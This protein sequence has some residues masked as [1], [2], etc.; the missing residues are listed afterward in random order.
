MLSYKGS[1]HATAGRCRCDPLFTSLANIDST[2]CQIWFPAP[3]A[4]SN[5]SDTSSLTKCGRLA[6]GIACKVKSRSGSSDHTCFRTDCGRTKQI[7]AKVIM[8]QFFFTSCVRSCNSWL[9]RALIQLNIISISDLLCCLIQEMRERKWPN[10]AGIVLVCI[11][12]WACTYVRPQP[13]IH[14]H[15]GPLARR[16]PKLAFS[17]PLLKLKLLFT[18]I[19]SW[20]NISSRTHLCCGGARGFGGVAE[21][22]FDM[23]GRQFGLKLTWKCGTIEA[24]HNT[25]E[26]TLPIQSALQQCFDD[27]FSPLK[28]E[29][30]HMSSVK[31]LSL[32]WMTIL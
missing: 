8:H 15:T 32:L 13:F 14:N 17:I 31:G 12:E 23:Q 1:W 3:N 27:T 11:A 6:H 18:S 30:C 29:Y 16:H 4:A 5:T 9:R 25:Y 22:G 24:S 28:I 19:G 20:S 26:I 21:W 10:E 2:F 7:S